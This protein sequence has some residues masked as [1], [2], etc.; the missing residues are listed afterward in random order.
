MALS[1]GEGWRVPPDPSVVEE[2]PDD[3]RAW[4]AQ[5]LT[6][7]PL[8]SF[9][10]P[11]RLRSPAAAALPR[12]FLQTTRSAL[13]DRLHRLARDA[14]WRGRALG[15]GHYPMLTQPQIVAGALAELAA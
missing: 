12:A 8:R 7:H 11:V 9:E 10:E 15:G 4:V 1:D 14:G 3:M 6:P 5:R 13:Y 2:L